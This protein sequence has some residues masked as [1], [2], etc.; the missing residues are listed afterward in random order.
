MHLANRQKDLDLK[1]K[2]LAETYLYN[3]III[4]V[5]DTPGSESQQIKYGK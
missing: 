2:K 3:D 4:L 5:V 1:C